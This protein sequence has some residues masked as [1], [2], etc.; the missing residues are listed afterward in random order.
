M[1]AAISRNRWRARPVPLRRDRRKPIF[2]SH[3]IGMPP[4][5]SEIR[6]GEAPSR[7][8]LGE[9]SPRPETA[10]FKVHWSGAMRLVSSTRLA[11]FSRGHEL[12]CPIRSDFSGN[13][14]ST[15]LQHN[16]MVCLYTGKCLD[17]RR[18]DES[19]Q[20]KLLSDTLL[21]QWL[22]QFASC[23]RLPALSRACEYLSEQRDWSWR[24]ALPG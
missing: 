13:Q 12:S 24:A 11:V 2:S 18:V 5:R 7:A 8:V 1:V 15:W 4:N 23:G 10:Y 20:L 22:R 17:R 6:R 14:R 9:S 19:F 21:N 3:V 16:S